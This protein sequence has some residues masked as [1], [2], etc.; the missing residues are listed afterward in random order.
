MNNDSIV[1]AAVV[2]GSHGALMLHV[3]PSK[4]AKHDVPCNPYDD[5][6]GRESRVSASSPRRLRRAWCAAQHAGGR[7]AR[8]IAH[9][10]LL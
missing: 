3:S 6:F 7:F 8:Q 10:R 2:P 9:E 1:I 5:A 4:K